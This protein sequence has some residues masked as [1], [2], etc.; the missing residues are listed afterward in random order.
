MRDDLI[1]VALSRF[2]LASEAE[3]QQRRREIDDLK[4]Q[5]PDLQ[6]PSDV[7][8]Q[9]GGQ[10]V[11]GVAVPPRPMLSIPKL[12]QPI[13]LVLNQEKAAHL[14]VQIH[15]QSEKANDETAETLQGL[16]RRIEVD[17]RAD[18]AR[19]WAFD[20]AVKAGRGV[21]RV[22]KE[23]A[24]DDT[25]DPASLSDQKL[26]IQRI[27][28][29]SSVYLDPFAQEPDWSD[30]E[31]CFIT[32]DVPWDRYKREFKDSEM[33]AYGDDEFRGLGDELPGWVGGD[34]ADSRT[35]RIAEY[36]RKEWTTETIDL[37][38]GRTRKKRVA[39]VLW[40]K[41]N[42]I[43]ELEK[44][45]WD[46]QYIPIIPV[47]GRELQPFDGE[48]RWVGMIGPAKDGQRLFNYAASA[49]VEKEA[50]ETKAPWVGAEGFAEGHEVEWAQSNTRNFPYLEYKP[51]T[52]AG[53]QTLPPQRNV[54]GANIS[55]SLELLREADEFIKASTFSFD[56]TLGKLSNKDRSGK[57]I[58]AQQQQSDAGNSH[59]LDNLATISLTYE[60]KVILDLIP[61]IYDRP[62]RVER[63]LGIDDEPQQVMLNAPFMP[64]PDGGMPQPAPPN[65]K[66]DQVKHYDLNGGSY[67]VTV[68]V[69]KSYQTKLQQG[70]DEFGML[71]QAEPQ[72]FAL[73][74]DIYL[75]FRDFPGHTE[76]A[77]RVK[78]ML[79]PQAQE[80]GQNGQASPEEMQQ[81]LAQLQQQLQLA[82]AIIEKDLAKYQGQAQIEQVKAQSQL[83][84][85]AAEADLTFQTMKLDHEFQVK[86]QG[87]K[88]ATA[89]QIKEL[90]AQMKGLQITHDAQHEAQA[91][92]HEARQSDLDRTHDV[93]MTAAG[94]QQQAEQGDL[95]HQ[96]AL[97]AG[98]QGQAFELER[99]AAEPQPEEAEV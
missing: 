66:P 22:N 88:D 85:K 78:R 20:R 57:A 90:D 10:V 49:A 39:K 74:G 89:L 65:A 40:S 55:A 41:I 48:R 9:R 70:A 24:H 5:I 44:E 30:G 98:E 16:Y 94:A 33:A 31:W 97:E 58:L 15:P 72:L 17:S 14:G 99:M 71:F 19:G 46:G 35:V 93:G 50:L 13:Q 59:Y 76:A 43:E 75:K 4:F 62:G 86:L 23:W 63:I 84:L 34:D 7:K 79:P 61:K 12:D 26:V 82:S 3:T 68:S 53:Q 51:T 32:A 69:G 54:A 91:L 60:A 37:G 95:D 21:Y 56:A 2:K 27:L 42:G 8:T 47:I 52:I 11:G 67:A 96:R 1:T 28:H 6:W 92:A 73:L 29:Q 64:G 81:Q 45:E 18:L 25:D 38:D 36:F 80:P 83:Q 77:E 87:M